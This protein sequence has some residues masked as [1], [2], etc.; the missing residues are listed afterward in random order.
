MYTIQ[1]LKAWLNLRDYD[2]FDGYN[3]IVPDIDTEYK[4]VASD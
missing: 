1:E 2:G 3:T 4:G